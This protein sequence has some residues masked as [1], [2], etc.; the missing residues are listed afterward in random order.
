MSVILQG[1]GADERSTAKSN[2]PEFAAKE[3][4]PSIVVQGPTHCGRA[5]S[6]S[7]AGAGSGPAWPTWSCACGFRVDADVSDFADSIWSAAARVESLEWEMDAARDA[8]ALA[9]RAAAVAGLPTA[10]LRLASGL[11]EA[12]LRELL[13]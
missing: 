5:M 8:L 3:P 4:R 2:A 1:P 7:G 10:E 13:S 6:H 11:D 12:A 9:V